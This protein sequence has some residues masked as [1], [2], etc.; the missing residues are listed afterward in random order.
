MF[1]DLSFAQTTTSCYYATLHL[2]ATKIL[3]NVIHKKG[4]Q[5]C[6]FSL[7]SID[8]LQRSKSVRRGMFIYLDIE[9]YSSSI[10]M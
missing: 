1:V 9:I 8:Y 7:A 2:E 3:A 5:F 6:R 4:P 10:E